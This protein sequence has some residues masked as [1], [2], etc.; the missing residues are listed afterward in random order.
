MQQLAPC[1]SQPHFDLNPYGLMSLWDMI[2]FRCS[3]A[4]WALELLRE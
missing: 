3:D 2:N 4:F 1:P